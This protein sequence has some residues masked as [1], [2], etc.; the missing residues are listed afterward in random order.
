MNN[1]AE[2]GVVLDA[3][4]FAVNRVV[5]ETADAVVFWSVQGAVYDAV[6]Q[7][8]FPGVVPKAVGIAT[9]H[10]FDHISLRVFLRELEVEA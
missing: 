6:A 8:V 5:I 10:D 2:N 3:L 4:F 1:T 9:Q 7:A